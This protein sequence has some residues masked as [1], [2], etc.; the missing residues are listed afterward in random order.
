MGLNSS[1]GWTDAKTR[2]LFF[3]NRPSGHP[4]LQA[5]PV[6]S[7]SL[8]KRRP[9][10][11]LFF[12]EWDGLN[13]TGPWIYPVDLSRLFWQLIHARANSWF[14]GGLASRGSWGAAGWTGFPVEALVFGRKPPLL[15][16][17]RI[18]LIKFETACN[19]R[20]FKFLLHTSESHDRV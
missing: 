13:E 2:S 8:E 10:R 12:A 6:L 7:C 16:Q 20:K 1:L 11:E 17:S 9:S 4:S 3:V 19:F 18:S 15:S 5:I 14:D